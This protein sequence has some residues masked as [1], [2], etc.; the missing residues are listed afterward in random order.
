MTLS[1]TKTAPV[2]QLNVPTVKHLP[3]GLT[4]IAEQVPVDAVNLSVWMK[5]GSAV[6]SDAI[7]GMAHF[8]EHMMFKGTAHLGNGEFEHRVEQRGALTNA[9]T[10]QEYTHYHITSAPRDFADLAPL[11]LDVVCNPI[12]P[13]EAFERERSVILEEIRRANDHPGR[14]AFFKAM[15]TAFESLP[16]RRPVLGRTEVIES[17]TSQQMR[18]FHRFWYQPS[19]MTAV[20][21]GNLPTDELIDIVIDGC[22]HAAL[23]NQNKPTIH[24]SFE[25]QSHA[26]E[27]SFST[28]IR[29]DYCDPSLS[30][31]RLMLMW[32]VPGMNCLDQTY[33]LDILASVLTGGRTSRLI[34]EL[35]EEKGLVSGVSVSNMTY[36]HQGIFYI[37]VH[38][39]DDHVDEVERIIIHH[40][41]NLHDQP[42]ADHELQ[43]IQTQVANR[44]V[45]G[46]E[47]P[48][49]RAGLYGYYQT[50]TG[51]LGPA[52][53]YPSHIRNLTAQDLQKTAQR[54]LDPKAYSAVVIHP[55]E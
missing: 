28:V 45:F 27:P 23:F 16:Y 36:V 1:V 35:R 44:Y 39:S 21:V 13:N 24:P 32:R 52:I 12:I 9:A 54:Y 14:R 53:S 46:N 34:R 19:A 43:R 48:D 4:V 11:Q 38:L 31:A 33:P 40:I 5:V 20:A 6:E 3:S 30:Q 29:Q 51:H 7:N 49:N 41:A 55:T 17:L 15:Q 26:P 10:S 37:V 2:S 22:D 50:L 47:T 42:V 18:D 8:L 25:S